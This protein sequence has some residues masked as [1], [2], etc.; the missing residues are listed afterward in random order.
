MPF[1][2]G[3]A[4]PFYTGASTSSDE[5]FDVAI[6]GHGYMI[7]T[8][9]MRDSQSL[10][11][12]GFGR[13]TVSMIR[14]Q[15]DTANKPGEASLNPEGL[16]RRSLESWHHG[17]GQ[18]WYDKPDSD[19]F[20]FRASKGVDPWTKYALTLLPDTTQAASSANTNLAL[21]VASG[22]LYMI[23]GTGV[24]VTGVGNTTF[25]AA[26]G[27]PAG[28]PTS[29]T[30]DGTSVYVSYASPAGNGVWASSGTAFTQYVTTGG[31]TPL[32]R[33][34]K[35]RLLAF[36]ASIYNPI[37]TGA[38]PAAL[39]TPSPTITWVDATE[40]PNHIFIAGYRADQSWVYK[41]AVKQDGTALDVPTVA[42]TLPDGEIVRSLQGYLGF[43]IIGTDKGVRFAT[44]DGNGNLTLGSVIPTSSPVLCAEG[45]DRFVWYGLTNYDLTSTGLGRLDLQNFTDNDTPAWASDLMATGQGSV[46]SVVTYIGKRVF[47][48]SGLGC[49]IESGSKVPTG[50][51]DSGRITYGIPDNKTAIVLEVR[52]D[53]LPVSAQVTLAVAIDSGS[54]VVAGVSSLTGTSVSPPDAFELNQARGTYF[55]I[56]STLAGALTLRRVTM[57][58][59]PSATRTVIYQV[60]VLLFDTI[61]IGPVQTHMDVQAE[62]SYLIELFESRQVVNYQ[63]ANDT[64]R[65]VVD[66]FTWKPDHRAADFWNG[67]LVLRL[68]GV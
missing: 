14:Q 65:V 41:T 55:E 56:T 39:W 33:Y 15:A 21:A 31:D 30:S 20:R 49:Y 51:I 48:V 61:N 47:T 5:R 34:V 16:W 19:S 6:G 64:Y 35:G 3:L 9:Y 10:S 18:T 67:T 24:K 32:V 66:D 58:A 59:D 45:Q 11:S 54:P 25:A 50:T 60:P 22:R 37:T 53:P 8:A 40:G 2:T 57:Q 63:E 28:S 23:D 26:T 62:F 17:A 68:K 44:P 4:P 43:V 7:D 52:H 12:L 36:S 13:D 38:Y 27:L 1:G 29:I 46:T 42:A